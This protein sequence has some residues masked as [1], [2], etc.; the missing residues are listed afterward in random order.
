[1]AFDSVQGT[2]SAAH[3][4]NN[5]FVRKAAIQVSTFTNGGA[6][7]PRQAETFMKIH[8]KESNILGRC[9]T[10]MIPTSEY[11]VD[12]IGFTGQVLLPDEEDVAFA[13][14]DLAVPETGKVTMNSK[15]YKAEFGLTYDTL[16]RVVQGNELMDILVE[17][18]AKA[19][20]R[21][22]ET[23]ALRGD[24]SLAPTSKLN[25]LLRKQDGFL[26]LITSNVVDAEGARLS[27][28]LMD[29]VQRAMPKEYR[30]QKGLC[31]IGSGNFPIDY[32]ALIRA[33]ATQL[34]DQAILGS[35]PTEYDG[36]Y[37]IIGASLM[38]D[39]LTYNSE[40]VHTNLL[41]TSPQEQLRVGYLEEMSIR[42][43]E[44]IRAG[45]FIVVLRFDVAFTVTHN[46]ANVKVTNL[47]DVP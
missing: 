1:M 10:T 16:K 38:P 7:L 14:S 34:G 32:K 37:P 11:T 24:T 17:E 31:Y 20:R 28:D 26:K 12:K 30:D 19:S 25:R 45:K 43:A 23:A 39:D 21:D 3:A 2:L 29:D 5:D 47:R 40:S 9:F 35:T 8:I 18:L 33:R 22:L 27:L 46:Q 44:D 6:L 13:Q 36:R 4:S 42:T 41:F 15:R